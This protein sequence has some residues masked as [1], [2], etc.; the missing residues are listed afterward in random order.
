MNCYNGDKYLEKSINS[1][2]S[3]TYKN[4]ELIILCLG[5]ESGIYEKI[6]KARAIKK[7]YKEIA[8]TGY[9]KHKFKI[10]NTSQFFLKEGPLAILPFSN[11]YF[12]F[13][14][15]LKKQKKAF[16]HFFSRP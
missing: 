7:N 2:I 12:S 1:L 5:G 8:V 16:L 6:I 14:W 3:Q 10:V 9:V 4:Y 13:V 11:N 15:S